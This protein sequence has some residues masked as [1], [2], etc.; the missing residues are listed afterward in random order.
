[1]KPLG[2]GRPVTPVDG[3]PSDPSPVGRRPG[4]AASVA[5]S[6]AAGVVLAAV[7]AMLVY[8]AATQAITHDEAITWRSH[9]GGP[10]ALPWGSGV[11]NHI[12]FTLLARLTTGVFGPSEF[13]LRLPT[14][15]AA[16]LFLCSAWVL[17]RR[18]LSSA[19]T[20]ACALALLVLNPYVLD[21]FAAAR[22]YGLGLAFVLWAF[23]ELHAWSYD[24][25]PVRL[26]RAGAAAG[27][28][29]P[30]QLTFA[31]FVLALV[32]TLAAW[33]LLAGPGAE[34]RRGGAARLRRAARSLAL[35][36]AAGIV[37]GVPLVAILMRELVVN[38]FGGVDNLAVTGTQLANASLVHVRDEFVAGGRAA[39][40]SAALHFAS[41]WVLPALFVL[42]V[43]AWCRLAWRA[44]R[45]D[46]PSLSPSERLLFLAG[47]VAWLAPAVLVA[48]VWGMP[49]IGKQFIYP[50]ARRAVWFLPVF[51]LAVAALVDVLLAGG[52]QA[53]VGG[54]GR[55]VGRALLLVLVL[56][57]GRFAYQLQV[58]YF[59]D[60]R[61]DAGS[62]RIFTE[63]ERHRAARRTGRVGARRARLGV[64][65]WLYEPSLNHYRG[66]EASDWMWPITSFLERGLEY[67]YVVVGPGLDP[68]AAR[69]RGELVFQDPVSRAWL[70]APYPREE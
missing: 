24:R 61:Y 25:R 58:S 10:H 12:L 41:A 48:L 34:D 67:D 50:G 49:L 33:E 6:V 64:T 63:L 38:F 47:G 2:G 15:F 43:V 44:I 11:N 21:F 55:W 1:M 39:W 69:Q 5:A 40:V 35:F 66:L 13:S 56:A 60:W 7:F 30:A 32:G 36:G 54:W 45:A 27:L 3:L 9:I 14:L 37:A 16:L 17:C 46:G 51:A 62:R 52:P 4:V 42:V 26:L 29:V 57:A 31:P 8:R 20:L 59:Y 23:V 19:A 53:R 18:A 22:G 65:P 68:D 28:T 70:I